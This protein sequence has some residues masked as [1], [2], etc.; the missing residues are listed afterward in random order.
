[1]KELKRIKLKDVCDKQTLNVDGLSK[2]IGGV[3]LDDGCGSSVCN[4]N[5][6]YGTKYCSGGAVCTSGVGVCNRNT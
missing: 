4:D 2:I 6:D 5:R 3:D 1:M